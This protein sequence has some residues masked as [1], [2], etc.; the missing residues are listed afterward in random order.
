M[1]VCSDDLPGVINSRECREHSFGERRIDGRVL[2]IFPDKPMKKP[3][4]SRAK[5]IS[6]V[7]PHDVSEIV[8]TQRYC[9]VGT[10]KIKNSDLAVSCRV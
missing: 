10:R 7:L 8:D 2:A 6:P 3:L 9:A 5:K 4:Q 1:Q